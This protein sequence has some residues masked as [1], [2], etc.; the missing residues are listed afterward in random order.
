MDVMGM[1]SWRDSCFEVEDRMDACWAQW[2]TK[3]LPI[4][5]KSLQRRRSEAIL[6]A[7]TGSGL[8]V[9]PCQREFNSSPKN[10][11]SNAF[12]REGGGDAFTVKVDTPPHTSYLPG[13]FKCYVSGRYI[14]PDCKYSR[15]EDYRFARLTAEGNDSPL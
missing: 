13:E 5:L 8:E 4:C 6:P 1:R 15:G 10:V 12:A 9:I 14:V 3:I 2:G 11:E 7:N